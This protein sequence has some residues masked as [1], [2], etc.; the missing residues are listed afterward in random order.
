MRMIKV[1]EDVGQPNL[2]VELTSS[3]AAKP[4]VGNVRRV[5]SVSLWH[6]WCDAV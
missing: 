3:P 2:K 6:A 5:F 1:V 4:G